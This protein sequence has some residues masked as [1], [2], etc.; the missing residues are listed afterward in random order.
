MQETVHITTSVPVLSMGSSD[1]T[2]AWN[3]PML[4]SSSEENA[5][6]SKATRARRMR[7]QPGAR[8]GVRRNRACGDASIR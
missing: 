8:G 1:T 5:A 7:A 2:Q 6:A 3:G 4:S